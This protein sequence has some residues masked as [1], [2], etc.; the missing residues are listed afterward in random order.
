MFY[1]FDRYDLSPVSTE[2]YDQN[3]DILEYARESGDLD[4]RSYRD[5]LH[6]RVI[7]GVLMGH[8]RVEQPTVQEEKLDDIIDSLSENR[9]EPNSG[10]GGLSGASNLFREYYRRANWDPSF[11]TKDS[12]KIKEYKRK[13]PYWN[14]VSEYEKKADI[15]KGRK[16]PTFLGWAGGLPASFSQGSAILAGG[17]LGFLIG[18]SIS[19]IQESRYRA[20]S[21]GIQ[22]KVEDTLYE[23]IVDSY[24]E[25]FNDLTVEVI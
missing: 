9:K 11:E 22:K 13:A 5:Y 8:D 7:D 10:F 23:G 18:F 12:S 20:R 1:E 19:S 14:T 4:I 24:M 25:D 16:L 3:I 6:P 15:N 17:G 2:F 21:A